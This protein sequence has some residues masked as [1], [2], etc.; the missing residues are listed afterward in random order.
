M[1]RQEI[2]TAPD[3]R[4]VLGDKDNLAFNT[5]RLG[6]EDDENYLF[7][8]LKKHGFKARGEAAPSGVED[9]GCRRSSCSG[10]SA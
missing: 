4:P 9:T 2:R 8:L 6:L 7:E 3:G 1:S 10:S 5:D